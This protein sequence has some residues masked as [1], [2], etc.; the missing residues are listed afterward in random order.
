M[1]LDEKFTAEI[2]DYLESPADSRNLEKGAT[3]LLQLTRNRIMFRQMMCNLNKYAPHIEYQLKKFYGAR[4]Q[5]ATHE[6]VEAMA[7][8]VTGIVDRHL[9]LQDD[10]PA[11]EFKAGKRADH[12]QLPE[13]IQAL[14][15]EN[16]SLVQ[17]MREVHTRLRLMMQRED[18]RV[19]PDS[20]RYPFLKELIALD[21]QLHDN[22][23]KYDS[24]DVEKGKM[25]LRV[26]ARDQAGKTLKVLNLQK[27]LYR[28]K[29]SGER[30]VKIE[31]LYRSLPNPSEKLT[32]ELRELGIIE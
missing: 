5:T 20:D 2:R 14:Y 4:V 11:S 22:W 30:A 23:E 19:C 12:D 15:V 10:N 13:T 7:A 32:D 21:K 26:S 9:S 17:R 24:W 16:K 29:P 1:R 31:E 8:R 6:E 28:K 3:L 25:A 27:V 18:G